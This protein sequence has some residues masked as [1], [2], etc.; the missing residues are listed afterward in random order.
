MR[1]LLLALPLIVVGCADQEGVLLNACKAHNAA[2]TALAPQIADS[3][4]SQRQV[5]A[6]FQSEETGNSICDGTVTD[7]TTALTVLEA[8]ALR[9][10]IIQSEE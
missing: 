6:I 2:L 4:F 8:E 9:L 10:A 1:K 7:F 5:D 3:Q